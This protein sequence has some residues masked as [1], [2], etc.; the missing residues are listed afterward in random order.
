MEDCVMTEQDLLNVI[1]DEGASASE[2]EAA[3][4][5][6]KRITGR[7]RSDLAADYIRQA[8]HAAREPEQPRADPERPAH[9]KALAVGLLTLITLPA[10]GVLAVNFG[11]GAFA[12][13]AAAVIGTLAVGQVRARWRAAAP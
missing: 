11:A 2:R 13:A 3:I 8:A 10:I 12:V 7:D 1:L 9:G 6:L 5:A 4:K